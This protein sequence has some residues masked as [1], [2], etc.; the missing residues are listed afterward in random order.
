MLVCKVRMVNNQK[1]KLST[2][3]KKRWARGDNSL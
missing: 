1:G 3:K 2:K